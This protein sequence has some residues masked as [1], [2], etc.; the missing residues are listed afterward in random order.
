MASSRSYRRT[1]GRSTGSSSYSS[2]SN[3]WGYR[4]SGYRT[5]G[6]STST[7]GAGYSPTQFSSVKKSIQQ[8]I[9]SFRN[10]QGQFTGG[11]R[12]TAFSP[13]AANKWVRYINNGAFVYKFS[14]SEFCRQFGARFGQPG[15]STSNVARTL[16][17]KFGTG[18]K[19]VTRGKGGC[20]L[21]AASARVT[22][23]PFSSYKW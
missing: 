8:C 9:G 17:A 16:K 6:G 19:D 15:T 22:G 13:T 5:G 1:T 12:V 21:I 3:R 18:I 10:I 20:W 7:G 2:S 4:G 11:G 23:Y 14:N